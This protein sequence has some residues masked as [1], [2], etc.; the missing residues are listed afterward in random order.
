MIPQRSTA[1]AAAYDLFSVEDK[2][3]PPYSAPCHLTERIVAVDTGVSIHVPDGFAALVCPR[4]GMALNR[5][6]SIV[7]SPGIIDPDYRGNIKVILINLGDY[8]F[9]VYKNDRI[10]QLLITSAYTGALQAQLNLEES[11]RGADGF[12]STGR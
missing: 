1:G 2:T 3:I 4:S 11:E 10:A 9:H 5:G 12:G 6:I 7:N 8:N